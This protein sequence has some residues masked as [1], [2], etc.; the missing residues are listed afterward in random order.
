MAK[1][2]DGRMKQ[3]VHNLR[4]FLVVAPPTIHAITL[5]AS[6]KKYEFVSRG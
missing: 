5:A 4:G 6:I 3:Q 1:T 2:A